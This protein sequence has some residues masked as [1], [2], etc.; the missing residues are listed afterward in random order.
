[1]IF[2]SPFCHMQNSMFIDGTR[3]KM[4][5]CVCLPFQNVTTVYKQAP[6]LMLIYHILRLNLFLTHS[7]A[8][9]MDDFFYEVRNSYFNKRILLQIDTSLIYSDYEDALVHV[10]NSILGKVGLNRN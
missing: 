6:L 8:I 10:C 2:L 3:Y 1:M 5:T 9:W 4:S 7:Q